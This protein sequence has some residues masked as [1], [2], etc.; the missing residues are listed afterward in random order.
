MPPPCTGRMDQ[1]VRDSVRPMQVFHAFARDAV[2][3]W[4]RGG[5][6]IRDFAAVADRIAD[7]ERRA[8]TIAFSGET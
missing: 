3:F 8:G 5:F 4:R 2:F 7:P 1:S 6:P